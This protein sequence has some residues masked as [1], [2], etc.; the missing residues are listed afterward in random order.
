M[1]R[2]DDVDDR[3]L[4]E[5]RTDARITNAKLAELVG[6]SE[7]ACLRRVRRMEEDGTIRGYTT[8]LDGRAGK[9][10]TVVFVQITLERQTAECLS[11]F[12]KAARACPEIRECHLM[13]GG[14]D[15][16]IQVLVRDMQE[17]EQLHR[18]VLSTLPGVS[19]IESSF[20]IRPVIQSR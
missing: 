20:T 15:Y 1:A 12:E 5:L 17:Y 10:G 3:I 14:Y 13:T 11:R 19:R 7:S 16:Q 4:S 18:A 8:V 6:L 9:T 2:L